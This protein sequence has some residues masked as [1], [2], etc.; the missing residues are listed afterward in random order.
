MV[1]EYFDESLAPAPGGEGRIAEPGHQF[2]WAWLVDRVYKRS[3]HDSRNLA[4]RMHVNG[5]VYGVDPATGVIADEIWVEGGVKLA[6]SRLWPHTERLKANLVHFERTGDPNSA[7]AAVQAFDALMAYCDV[8]KPG[9]WRDR[10][11]ANGAWADGPAPA[12][13]FYHIMLALTE[14]IRVANNDSLTS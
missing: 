14:L 7:D 5:E 4:R 9:L 2:E 10:R 1:L 11:L 6:S 12:S 8:P 13:S 3:G